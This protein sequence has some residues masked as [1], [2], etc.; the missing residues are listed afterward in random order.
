MEKKQSRAHC[1][2]DKLQQLNFYVK[3]TVLDLES[4]LAIKD[5]IESQGDIKVA[6]FTE[7]SMFTR[8]QLHSLN[9][10]CRATHTAFINTSQTSLFGSCFND[11]GPTF[12]VIDKNGEEAE[13]SMIKSIELNDK[14]KVVVTVL[15]QR[16][17]FEDGDV[18]QFREVNGL[19]DSQGKSI[20]DMKDVKISVINPQKFELLNFDLQK[21]SKYESAGIAKQIKIPLTLSFKTLQEIDQE[22]DHLEFFDQNLIYSDFSKTD[23]I[24]IL[25][26]V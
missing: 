2:R 8:D 4:P 17:K 18:V 15:G 5:Y 20:N 23:N 21:Y 14:G 10:T 22:A 13:E 19:V 11:F 3:I 26:Y 12:T 1:S 6:V 16:H 9:N 24:R 7:H 25:H